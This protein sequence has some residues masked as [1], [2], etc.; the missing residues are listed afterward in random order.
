M[1]LVDRQQPYRSS[2]HGLQEMRTAEPF[3]SH[4]DEAV[5]AGRHLRQALV[6]LRHV[7]RAVDQR[8]LHAPGLHAID[9]I[10]HQR[11]QGRDHDGHAVAGHG[12]QLVA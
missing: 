9:L 7:Q 6:L 2:T 5:L 11:D 8:G 12:R 10:L 1:G 3:R 4:V